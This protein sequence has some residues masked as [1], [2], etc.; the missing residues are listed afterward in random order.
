MTGR[1]PVRTVPILLLSGLCALGPATFAI[2]LPA[3]DAMTAGFELNRST[4]VATLFGCL[5]GT[6]TGLFVVSRE[7]DR[8]HA[9]LLALATYAVTGMACA[10]AP[11]R[12]GFTFSYFLLGVPA[13]ACA[14]VAWLIGRELL[15]P[16]QQLAM[17]LIACVYAV[18]AVIAGDELLGPVQW[19]G[20][21]A[22]MSE[23]SALLALAVWVRLPSY[24]FHHPPLLIRAQPH[25]RRPGHHDQRVAAHGDD[26]DLAGRR[27]WIGLGV[28]ALPCIL[29][30]MDL[31]VLN[32]TI[33][34]LT[35]DLHPTSTELL[36]IVDIYG[37]LL[38]AAL[39]T[40]GTIGDRIGRRRL[41]MIGAFAFGIASVAAAFSTSPEMLIATR[42]LL[43]LA[44]A[45]LAPSTL[46]LIRNMFRNPRQRTFAIGVWSI[47]YAVGAVIGPI[48]G[49]LLLEHFWWGSV[50]ILAV[51]VMVL[52]LIVGPLLLPEFKNPDAGRLDIPSALLSLAAVLLTV[53]GLKHMASEGID[54][55][56]VVCTAVG[57]ALAALFIVRQKHITHALIDLDL[58]RRREFHAPV[59]INL[60]IYF[61]LFGSLLFVMQYLQLVKGF[62]PLRAGVHTI[63][64]AVAL[65]VGAIVG[66]LLVGKLRPVHII[67]C[68]FTIAALGFYL[69]SRTVD[70]E[71]LTLLITGCFLSYLGLALTITLATD[72]I[73]G[74]APPQRAGAASAVSETTSELGGALGIAVLGAIGTSV[75][76]SD[77]EKS[78]SPGLPEA[79]TSLPDET[80][81]DALAATD[82]LPPE[83]RDAVSSSAIEAFMDALQTATSTSAA[84]ALV[85]AAASIALLRKPPRVIEMQHDAAAKAAAGTISTP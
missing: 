3:I 4:A 52:L 2:C 47:S 70:A 14:R 65:I 17:V 8:R 31:T 10:V 73:V 57:S 82:S 20:L 74:A 6:I 35:A 16:I 58:F 44:G 15:P 37:F 41:L 45:T 80:F 19:R 62:S 66:P 27:E 36:W 85:I 40:M 42:A 48:G 59:V 77:F 9:L 29:Y 46:S 51:P 5:A 61:V 78:L 55:R 79:V 7:T 12:W 39:I 49:G 56:T 54:V 53:Y 76:E 71:D 30:S 28:I 24:D 22:A 33:P 72:M 13:G 68:G 81:A 18:A 1:V 63:P 43:G 23:M 25:G 21:L 26:S 83:L 69:T 75:Y 60:F 67:S 34:Y 50:F 11:G 84:V 38:A 32:M 64:M